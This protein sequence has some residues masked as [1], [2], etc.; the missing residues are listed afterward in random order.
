MVFGRACGAT[1]TTLNA[2]R[3]TL[4]SPDCWLSENQAWL[5]ATNGHP[6]NVITTI[7]G[8]WASNG[9][10]ST[11]IGCLL[12]RSRC[13]DTPFRAQSAAS[14]RPDAASSCQMFTGVSPGAPKAL[15]RRQLAAQTLPKLLKS[16]QKCS[17]ERLLKRSEPQDATG[18]P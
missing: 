6:R 13:L 11:I 17:R 4:S 15:W 8:A 16:L 9:F 2:K 7:A 14:D 3:I 18:E 12:A 10:L 5:L 1:S